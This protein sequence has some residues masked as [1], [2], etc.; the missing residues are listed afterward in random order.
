MERFRQRDY[1][2]LLVI[3]FLSVLA[4]LGVWPTL[5][6]GFLGGLLFGLILMYIEIHGLRTVPKDLSEFSD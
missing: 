2:F 3:L 4:L 5:I 6:T 1:A